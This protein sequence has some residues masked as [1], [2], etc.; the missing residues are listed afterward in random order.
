MPVSH[1]AM[2]RCQREKAQPKYS[3]L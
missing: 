2:T 1:T 3:W